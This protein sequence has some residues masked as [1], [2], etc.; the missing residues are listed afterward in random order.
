MV[1]QEISGSN[2]STRMLPV[3]SPR[4]DANDAG[5]KGGAVGGAR[6]L[7]QKNQAERCNPRPIKEFL[8]GKDNE[9]TNKEEFSKLNDLDQRYHVTRF[10]DDEARQHSRQTVEENMNRLYYLY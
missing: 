3:R 6:S 10:D 1:G 8:D 5:D 2:D 4:S 7:A 9:M